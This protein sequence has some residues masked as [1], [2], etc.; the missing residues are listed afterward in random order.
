[1]K[2]MFT[3]LGVMALTLGLSFGS[4][5]AQTSGQYGTQSGS[6]DQY[7]TQPQGYGQSQGMTREDRMQQDRMQQ[8]GRM[9]QQGQ[10]MDQQL[11]GWQG[12]QFKASKFIGSSVYNTQGEKLGKVEDLMIDP[13]STRVP[14]AVISHDGKY[15]A[16]PFNAL[17]YGTQ[18]DTFVLNMSKDRLTQAPTFDK[19]HW[20]NPDDRAWSSD[21]YRFYGMRPHWEGG[22]R[23]GS[24]S[25]QQ[26]MDQSGTRSSQTR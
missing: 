10:M 21:V 12:D 24:F 20:P 8:Q 7:G 16:V 2:K 9:N 13:H 22:M 17:Q 3:T 5:Y 26:G 18:K 11:A 15:S 6:Q 14:F 19:N 1:M 23:Q 25:G 4:L